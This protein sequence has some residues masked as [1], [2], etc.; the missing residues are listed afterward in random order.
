MGC[1]QG[2]TCRINFDNN[3]SM[4]A[5]TERLTI[6]DLKL[7]IGVS[8]KQ[9][10][11]RI[12]VQNL[13]NLAGYFDCV[14]NY[15]DKLELTASQQTDVKDLAYCKNTTIAMAEALKLWCQPNPFSSTYRAL[16]EILLDLRRGDVAIKVSHFIKDNL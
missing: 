8:D 15:L 9:L 4:L 16:L 14:E 1:I 11:E 5:D 2:I 7:K 6:E 12:D 3:P 10:D 13:H